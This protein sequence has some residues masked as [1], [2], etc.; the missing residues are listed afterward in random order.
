MGVRNA[1]NFP[2]NREPVFLNNPN[3]QQF[4]FLAEKDDLLTTMTGTIGKRDFGWVVK[5]QNEDNFLVNQRVCRISPFK[6]IINPEFLYHVCFS[7]SYLDQFFMGGRGGTGNQTNVGVTDIANIL[8]PKPPTDEQIKISD[9]LSSAD[10]KIK[11]EELNREYLVKLKKAL[12]Q[13][14]LTGKVRVKI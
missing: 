13:V 6:N 3:D 9:I 14:L 11:N 1:R 10:L 5:I 7:K 4:Q 8:V 2:L 12:M